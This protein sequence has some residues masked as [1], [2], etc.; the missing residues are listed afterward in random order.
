MRLR[1]LAAAVM[2]LALGAPM[3]DAQTPPPKSLKI[4][5]ILDRTGL[6]SI[7]G[8]S[9]ARGLAVAI[10]DL[11]SGL[12]DAGSTRLI[13]SIHDA[14]GDPSR[15]AVLTQHLA[16]EGAKL[17]IG[18]T[19]SAE[20]FT[21]D[22]YAVRAGLPVLA[23]SDTAENVTAMGPCVFRNSLTEKQLASDV[24]AYAKRKWNVRSAAILFDPTVPYTRS[25][26][27]LFEDDLLRQQVDVVDVEPLRAGSTDVSSPLTTIA[28]KKPDVLVI[29]ALVPEASRILI[30][31]RRLGIQAH[32]VGE[33]I[34]GT[35]ALIAL[36]GKDADGLTVAPAYVA[37]TG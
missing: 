32:L 11:K 27:L 36:A 24:V 2:L 13:F 35:P 31:V 20:A 7:Y 18:P 28:A 9:Q 30:A 1:W 12:I 3:V 37:T 29:D 33:A 4:G 14:G 22:P 8:A 16:A 17:L 23:I 25:T 19:R 21:A 6:G 34:L 10:D 26:G 15:A 5:V